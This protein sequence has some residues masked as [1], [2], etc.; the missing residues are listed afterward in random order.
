MTHA[1]TLAEVVDLLHGWYPPATAD[2]WDAVGLVRGDPEAARPPGPAR[3]RPDAAGRRRGGG[4]GRRPA[5]GAPP[6]LPQGR[7]RGRRRPRRRAGRCTAGGGGCAL[8]TAH[9]NADG[10]TTASTSRSPARSDSRTSTPLQPAH[11]RRR[12][13]SSWSSSRS[14]HA[15][16]VR[17]ALAGAGAGAIGA[18]DSPRFTSPGEGR[19]RPFD[20]ASPRSAP[21]GD[22]RGGRRG[23]HRVGLPRAR[24]SRVVGRCWPH[25]PTR[26]RPATSSSS[27]TRDWPTTG[28]GRGSATV[29]SP[30]PWASFADHV[31]AALPAT[32]HGVRSPATPTGRCAR[33]PS[34]GGAGTSC[35][36]TLRRSDADVF[37]TSDL[38][39]H[40]AAEFLE[41]GGPA[42][43]D[44][45]HWAAEWTWLPVVRAQAGRQRWAIRW[46]PA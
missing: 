1:P 43:V 38:R 18:Y 10:P 46:R 4:L 7:A 41:Q 6:A 21:V 28:T 45:A 9:T 11:R 42:L 12:S 25:T 23:A 16:A 30:P 39:H 35:S 29:A 19:F 24:R 15:E 20:G 2:D 33:W 8:L 37:V 34:R 44:V 32:A 13:T 5:A 36:T 31:A 17:D 14:T 3:R 27:P 22:A 26:S 40:P